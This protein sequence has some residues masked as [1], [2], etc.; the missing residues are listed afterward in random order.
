MNSESQDLNGKL[1]LQQTLSTTSIEIA[2]LQNENSIQNCLLKNNDL[3]SCQELQAVC[4]VFHLD[5]YFRRE[6]DVN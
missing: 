5:L 6:L 4:H 1:D 2:L 3:Y